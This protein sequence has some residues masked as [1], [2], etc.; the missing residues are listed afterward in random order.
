MG[1][2]T[3][4]DAPWNR[5]RTKVTLT[6]R[7]PWQRRRS[8]SRPRSRSPITRRTPKASTTPDLRSPPPKA[9]SAG[10]DRKKASE[11]KAQ[12]DTFIV[13]DQER[14]ESSSSDGQDT[15]RKD[16]VRYRD[17]QNYTPDTTGQ[18][19]TRRSRRR[20]RDRRRQRPGKRER[21]FE[22]WWQQD[23]D[24][25]PPDQNDGGDGRE[26]RENRDPPEADSTSNVP[27]FPMDEDAADYD[28]E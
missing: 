19:T 6:S 22:A 13:S 12:P 5:P 15:D 1:S 28:D 14:M 18:T 20:S 26:G 16:R 7:P 3:F 21:L 23:Q 2:S 4:S 17:Q 27:D 9:Y 25:N 10:R 11:P 24:V 8:E